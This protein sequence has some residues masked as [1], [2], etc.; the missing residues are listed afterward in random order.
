MTEHTLKKL[1][2]RWLIREQEMMA[3]LRAL[4][5][6]K[7]RG[8]ERCWAGRPEE[9]DDVMRAYDDA[10]HVKNLLGEAIEWCREHKVPHTS[11]AFALGLQRNGSVVRRSRATGLS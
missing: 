7:R 4:L 9:F 8:A 11:W 10:K 2:Q 1:H 3:K 6:C 5:G